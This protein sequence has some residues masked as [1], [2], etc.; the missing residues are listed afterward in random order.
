MLGNVLGAHLS[1]HW[2]HNWIAGGPFDNVRHIILYDFAIHWFDI[3]TQ[4]M[5][6][7]KATR[8]FASNTHA[9]GQKAKPNLLGQ[10][11]I[12]YDG[13]QATLA[14]DASTPLGSQDRTYL[15]G[16][17]G[18]AI[19]VGTGLAKQTVTVYTP[20]GHFTPKLEGTWFPDGMLGSMAELLSSIEEDR[21]PQNNAR[22]NLASLAVCFAACKSADTGKPQIPGQV[23]KL[24]K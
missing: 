10:A 22:A 23:R 1:V 15:A 6:G 17:K 16:T 4:F 12:E 2:N 24:V 13:A 18:S 11:L 9:E 8:V 19:S 14:F 7:R 20:K 5:Q 3:V 21:V